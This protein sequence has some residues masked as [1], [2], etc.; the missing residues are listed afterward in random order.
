MSDLTRRR[1]AICEGEFES[2][3]FG[4]WVV[5]EAHHWHATGHRDEFCR[6]V[7]FC[8]EVPGGPCVRAHFFVRFC[9]GKTG[10]DECYAMIDGC[11]IGIE[12]ARSRRKAS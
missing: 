12:A 1:L 8:S 2:Y 5:E 4:A 11:L 6:T 10:I 7:L 9:P 3:G